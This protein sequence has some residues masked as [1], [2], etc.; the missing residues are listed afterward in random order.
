MR[1]SMIKHG[2]AFTLI[3]LLVVISII[4]LLVAILLPALGKARVSAQMAS[5]LTSVRQI[6]ISHHL[7]A[8]D[9]KG[10]LVFTGFGT[11]THPLPTWASHLVEK[12][13]LGSRRILWSPGR[14]TSQ[15]NLDGAFTSDIPWRYTGFGVNAWITATQGNNTNPAIVTASNVSKHPVNLGNN[16]YIV[17][18]KAMLMAEPSTDGVGFTFP[19]T[20]PGFYMVT[21]ST[22][23]SASNNL[24][25]Y[26]GAAV[27][28]YLDGHGSADSL[29]LGWI[30]TSKFYGR[31]IYTSASHRDAAP[32]YWRWWQK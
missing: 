11:A 8:N 23:T 10:S 12:Q 3:E 28:S 26:N 17:P 21:A 14:D 5:S 20:M 7:Y 1:P 6:T 9:N 22:N 4:S 13:Y 24:F 32:W 18:S 16:K 19:Q 15:L 25:T 29:A 2:S 31:W 30:P 27:H